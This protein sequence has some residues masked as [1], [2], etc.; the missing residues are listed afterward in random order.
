MNK[1]IQNIMVF[2]L[3]VFVI[4]GTIGYAMYS[5]SLASTKVSV[6]TSIE[7]WNV[8]FKN[9]SYSILNTSTNTNEFVPNLTDPNMQTKIKATVG[10]NEVFDFVIAVENEGTMDAIINGITLSGD[11]DDLDYSYS[12]YGKQYTKQTYPVEFVESPIELDK[13]KI[14]K[15]TIRNIKVHLEG[16]TSAASKERTIGLKLDFSK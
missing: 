9:G 12:W 11:I 14:E 13:D 7:K 5:N 4:C 3:S 8:H 6:D 15:E 16:K 2:I 10:E 1:R